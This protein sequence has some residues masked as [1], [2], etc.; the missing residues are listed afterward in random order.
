MEIRRFDISFNSKTAMDAQQ[1]QPSN[2]AGDYKYVRQCLTL[3][4]SFNFFIFF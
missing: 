4:C 1:T 3:V 2:N